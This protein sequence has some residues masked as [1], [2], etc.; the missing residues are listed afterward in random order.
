M[1]LMTF[2]LRCD[3]PSDGNNYWPYRINAIVE[4][5]R[6]QDPDVVGFQEVTDRMSSDLRPMFADY[7][8][9]GEGRNSDLTGEKC[10]VFIRKRLFGLTFTETFWLSSTPEIPGSMDLEEGF[11][12]IS[13]IVEFAWINDDSR[14][15]RVMNSHFAY[16]SERARLTNAEVLLRRYREVQDK[17][18]MP[19][20]IMGD[21]NIGPEHGIHKQIVSAGFLTPID[22]SAG[23]TYHGFIGGDGI[24]L[25]DFIYVSSDIMVKNWEIDRKKQDGRYPSDHYPVIADIEL[26]CEQ[27]K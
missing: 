1:K 14:R 12:R 3:V 23:S 26:K 11:P 4:T 15:M 25:L 27:R 9:M 2:N 22:K 21:L 10:S 17:R 18:P 16:R 20:V 7:Y 6:R 24:S 8:V 5:I 19:T 13:T